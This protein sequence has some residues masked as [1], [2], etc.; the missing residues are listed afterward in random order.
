MKILLKKIV[1][2]LVVIKLKINDV[3]IIKKDLVYNYELVIE[4]V[5]CKAKLDIGNTVD[6]TIRFDNEEMWE[7]LKKLTPIA[8]DFSDEDTLHDELEYYKNKY[9]DLRD[10]VNKMVINV[11][12]IYYNDI[13]EPNPIHNKIDNF[14]LDKD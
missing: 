9:K 1:L 11:E 8:K 7:L 3:E 12:Q 2:V 14:I 5:N 13:V 4:D 10:N 6:L